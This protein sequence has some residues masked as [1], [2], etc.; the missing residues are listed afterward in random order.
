M[1][2]F[3][4]LAGGGAAG[5]YQFGALKYIFE[6]TDIRPHKIWANS[7][8]SLNGAGISFAG[9]KET[10]KLWRS[11]RK[12]EDIFGSRFLGYVMPLFGSDSLW[13]SKPLAKLLA[14]ILKDRRPSIPLSVNYVDLCTGML[15]RCD[16]SSPGFEKFLLASA[17]IPVLVPPVDG[18]YVDGAIR[19]NTP[20][21]SAVEEAPDRIFV[22]L[23]SPKDRIMPYMEPA[24]NVKEI[25]AR[26]LAIMSDELLW[27][28]L[29]YHKY[30]KPEAEHSNL[31]KVSPQI[32]YLAPIKGTIDTLDFNKEKI[33]GAIKQGYWETHQTLKLLG[34]IGPDGK[35]VE[36]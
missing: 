30:D 13:N 4:V 3:F 14:G 19:E 12:R 17:S 1:K 33:D 23:N 34:V 35:A 28:D 36:L 24:K 31:N 15:N 20:L 25:A 2:T 9:L 7:A 18:R 27:G 29:L 22:F 11:I 6:Q 8:G 5:S 16:A 26:T 10:E 21:T 32:I